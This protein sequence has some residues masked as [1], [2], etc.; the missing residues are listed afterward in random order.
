MWGTKNDHFLKKEGDEG[1]H[2]DDNDDED[3]DEDEEDDEDDED[4]EEEEDYDEDG[5]WKL[6]VAMHWE[7]RQRQD[8]TPSS[9]SNPI[10][11][12]TSRVLYLIMSYW[13]S[14]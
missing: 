6:K 13:R 9:H 2:N 14:H 3:D 5:G 4:D 11:R 1:D 10:I 8:M 7:G 12:H